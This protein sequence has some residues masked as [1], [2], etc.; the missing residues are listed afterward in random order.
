M[1][2]LNTGMKDRKIVVDG[3]YKSDSRGMTVHPALLGGLNGFREITV[4]I[5][6]IDIE[7]KWELEEEA[8]RHITV[9]HLLYITPRSEEKGV[10]AQMDEAK[11]VN[12]RSKLSAEQRKGN[13]HE[14]PKAKTK[15]KEKD[16]F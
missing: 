16:E 7:G 1:N 4:L 15:A 13:L 8:A 5:E 2:E 12:F 10:Q 3:N 11:K 9:I 6:R 14:E